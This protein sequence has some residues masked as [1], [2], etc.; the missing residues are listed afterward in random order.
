MTICARGRKLSFFNN[1]NKFRA[2]AKFVPVAVLR[3]QKLSK[4]RYVRLLI[5]IIFIYNKLCLRAKFVVG[6]VLRFV[7][8]NL[9]RGL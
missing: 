7:V 3:F 6:S 5:W 1:W 2:Q 8:D 4:S 9:E